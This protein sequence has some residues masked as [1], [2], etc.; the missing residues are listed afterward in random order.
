MHE[1]REIM[2]EAAHLSLT[3]GNANDTRMQAQENG[4][5]TLS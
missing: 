1:A 2:L 3:R 5:S 4:F